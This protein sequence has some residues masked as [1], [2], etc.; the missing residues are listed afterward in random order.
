MDSPFIRYVPVSPPQV[1]GVK[2]RPEAPLYDLY[3][4][5]QFTDRERLEMLQYSGLAG[6]EE[7]TSP[8]LDVD[9]W[10]SVSSSRS[11][12]GDIPR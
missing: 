3:E 8:A 5:D 7:C 6:M 12:L 9:R 4:T 1:L 2:L 11:P 10:D